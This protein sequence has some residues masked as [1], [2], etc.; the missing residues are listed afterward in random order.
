MSAAPTCS[1]A[2]GHWT[3]SSLRT[4]RS[5][6]RGRSSAKRCHG[7][8]STPNWPPGLRS[9]SLADAEAAHNQPTTLGAPAPFP[10]LAD[11]ADRLSHLD[12]LPA[13]ESPAMD[14]RHAVDVPAARPCRFRPRRPPTV[15]RSADALAG[16]V[17]RQGPSRA[18]SRPRWR[19]AD[20]PEWDETLVR[21]GAHM[22]ERLG[23]PA[24]HRC[25]D[26]L[27]ADAGDQLQATHTPVALH[28]C[29]DLHV[30]LLRLSIAGLSPAR[31]R[32][33]CY[34]RTGTKSTCHSPKP[35]GPRRCNSA[36][37]TSACR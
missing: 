2:S 10:E 30:R 29:G 4:S 1:S 33:C 5:G 18:L 26:V 23:I 28:A 3:A 24:R 6:G 22:S 8:P 17:C 7:K 19:R 27:A 34:N 15:R 31:H 11:L 32:P 21:T 35:A 25:R 14:H 37:T 36:A 9:R 13:G 20:L 12:A 16:L